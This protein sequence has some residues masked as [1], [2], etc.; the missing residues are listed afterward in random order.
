M[1]VCV[2]LGGSLAECMLYALRLET[3]PEASTEWEIIH[4]HAIPN[5][6]TCFCNS[7]SC[8]KLTLIIIFPPSSCCKHGQ[9]DCMLILGLK[10]FANSWSSPAWVRWLLQS[11]S[12]HSLEHPL[13]GCCARIIGSQS[14]HSERLAVYWHVVW[15]RLP[16]APDWSQFTVAQ[17]GSPCR[18][19]VFAEVFIPCT[20]EKELGVRFSKRIRILDQHL[21]TQ[22]N[23]SALWQKRENTPTTRAEI[24][25]YWNPRVQKIFFNLDQFTEWSDGH[26][27]W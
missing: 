10:F 25:K 26:Y 11:P 24:S 19:L 18:L 3:V 27:H 16:V 7:S 9:Q 20:S 6:C 2:K 1:E 8:W 4:D 5:Y 22:K 17:L 15:S 13:P 23:K 12:P 14:N 21:L